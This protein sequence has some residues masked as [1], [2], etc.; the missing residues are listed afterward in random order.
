MEPTRDEQPLS[1]TLA[2]VLT[3]GGLILAGWIA[4]LVLLWERW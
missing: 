3:I 4:M 2:F 1:A